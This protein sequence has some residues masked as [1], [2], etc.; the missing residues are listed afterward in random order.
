MSDH[1]QKIRDY[2]R[3][4]P[5][6]LDRRA[7]TPCFLCGGAPADCTADLYDCRGRLRRVVLCERCF[8]LPEGEFVRRC[9]RRMGR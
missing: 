9:M 3:R 2:L 6:A 8:E 5:H 4:N 7:P 1:R